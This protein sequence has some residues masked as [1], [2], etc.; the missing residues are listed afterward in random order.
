MPTSL[1][2]YVPQRTSLARLIP[3][4][5]RLTQRTRHA[6]T[7]PTQR[8]DVNHWVFLDYNFNKEQC[9]LPEDDRMIETCSSVLSVLMWILDHRMNIC[10]FVGVLIK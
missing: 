5:I 3:N 9:S 10:A 7:A 8:N 6:A 1:T 4:S 2:L